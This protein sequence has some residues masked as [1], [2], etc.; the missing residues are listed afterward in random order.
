MRL[1]DVIAGEAR[2]SPLT[3]L[4]I[5]AA[6]AFGVAAVTATFM[7]LEAY[8]QASAAVLERKRADVEQRMD[9]M[10]DA[11]R[12]ISLELGFNVLI[13]PK[14]QSLV[15][16]YVDGAATKY[17]PE[18][19]AVKVAES[20]IVTVQHILPSL[21]QR[22]SWPEQDLTI[23]LI[24][25]RGEVPR[26]M[27]RKRKPILDVV[28]EG[29]IVLG[30]E[31]CTR[32]A[33]EKE[34]TVVLMGRRF[35]VEQCYEE[36]GNE[37]DMSAWINLGV[38][39]Q[40]LG[41]KGLINAILALECRCTADS[42]MLNIERI[43]ADIA[44]ILPDTRVVE[45]MSRALTRAEARHKA[46]TTAR[47][48]LA[49]EETHRAALIASRERFAA[50]VL[51]LVV[52]GVCAGIGVLMLVNMRARRYEIALLRTIGWSTARL[53]GLLL[54]KALL[55]GVAATVAGVGIGVGAAVVAARYGM[56]VDSGVALL[57][58]R[59]GVGVVLGG[60]ILVL[61]AAWLPVFAAATA[62]PAA[63]LQER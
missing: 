1:T 8:R 61:A 44:R 51:P 60:P 34:H 48:S 24:G 15:D 63:T 50:T 23:N 6:A 4:L 57:D 35:T 62:G 22:L 39:Q 55:L 11:Y 20:R 12:R 28:P 17:M 13:L 31:L 54:G 7:V 42:T 16:F 14:G 52:V 41:K 5:V 59:A 56:Q 2:H 30:H 19:Y 43:R 45:F 37:D 26:L 9:E 38:A 46:V 10:W 21:H 32:L 3:S 40:M 47:E 49:Q 36:R 53:F 58:W 27:G 33:V 18:E 29:K 25:V